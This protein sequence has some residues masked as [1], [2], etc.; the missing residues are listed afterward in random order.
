MGESLIGRL[1]G[2]LAKKPGRRLRHG[3]PALDAPARRI[4]RAIDRTA[5]VQCAGPAVDQQRSSP[6]SPATARRCGRCRTAGPHRISRARA[7]RGCR[8]RDRR[9]V[10]PRQRLHRRCIEPVRAQRPCLAGPRTLTM[11]PKP[12]PIRDNVELVAL[13]SSRFGGR[14]DGWQMRERADRRLSHIAQ[15]QCRGAERDVGAAACT[16][17]LNGWSEIERSEPPIR[18]LAPR[19]APTVASTVAPP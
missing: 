7:Q 10:A 16:W 18:A 13:F 19:P 2:V 15:G 6:P 5:A 11:I 3:T 17:A 1:K 12:E 4:S 9:G 8:P 14:A